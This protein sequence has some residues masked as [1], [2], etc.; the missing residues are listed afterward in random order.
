MGILNE[1]M[2]NDEIRNGG[3]PKDIHTE[4]VY[5]D[6]V[7]MPFPGYVRL[8]FRANNPGYWLLHCNYCF[9]QSVKIDF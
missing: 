8:R 1:T 4:P 5:K 6:T 2:T 7:I 9:S 3:I